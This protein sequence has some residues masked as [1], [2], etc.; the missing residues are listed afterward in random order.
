MVGGAED[1]VFSL[2]LSVSKAAYSVCCDP[3]LGCFS[4]DQVSL[5]IC[6]YGE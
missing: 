6:T 3:P 5:F 4:E 1:A 2:S